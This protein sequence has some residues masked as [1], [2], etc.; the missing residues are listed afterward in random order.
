[1]KHVSHREEHTHTRARAQRA[2]KTVSHRVRDQKSLHWWEFIK[3]AHRMITLNSWRARSKLNAISKDIITS[4]PF[5]IF[6]LFNR[7]HTIDLWN[8]INMRT[9]F[10]QY[11]IDENLIWKITK[12]KREQMTDGWIT[13]VLKSD[14]K[15]NKCHTNI[16]KKQRTNERFICVMKNLWARENQM[17]YVLILKNVKIGWRLCSFFALFMWCARYVSVFLGFVFFSF[18]FFGVLRVR[19]SVCLYTWFYFFICHSCSFEIL[20]SFAIFAVFG[21]SHTSATVSR[22]Y[23]YIALIISFGKSVYDYFTN[24]FFFIVFFSFTRKLVCL[25]NSF[26]LQ[27]EK[28]EYCHMKEKNVQFN[29]CLRVFNLIESVW[30][31]GHLCYAYRS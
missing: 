8:H 13:N 4:D 21:C 14:I 11:Y 25:V 28:K 15:S 16:I 10:S 29:I 27:K 17:V 3:R 23:V 6:W 22:L 18:R 26:A 30:D 19:I 12:K 9:R 5:N 31:G 20:S 1:M 2:P 7:I 24:I